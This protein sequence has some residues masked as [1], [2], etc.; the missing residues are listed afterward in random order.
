MARHWPA[1]PMY[2]FDIRNG[3]THAD[4]IGNE[5]P[6][7]AAAWR[8]AL[9]TAREIEDVLAPGNNWSM[10]V[11]REGTPLYHVEIRSELLEKE[12]ELESASPSVIP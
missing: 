6:N 11:R 7:D 9:R 3:A 2:F 10:T 8:E 4:E 1:M 12:A 5:L